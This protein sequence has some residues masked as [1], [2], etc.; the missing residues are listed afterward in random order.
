[1]Y[2]LDIPKQELITKKLIEIG[3]NYD[4]PLVA[5]QNSYYVE[6]EDKTTQDVIM[7]LGTGHEIENPDRPSLTAG[8][9]SFLDEESMQEIFG[10]I[11]EALENTKKI[12]D[13]VDIQ[14]ETGGVLIPKFKL[15]DEHYKIFLEA[16][17]YQKQNPG[18]TPK[19]ELSSDEWYLRYL[20][21]IGLN[22][23]YEEGISK[24]IIFELVQ[25]TDMPS[26]GKALTE[27]SPEELKT[28]SLTYYSKRKKEIL[29][30]LSEDMQNKIE[31]LEYELVVVHE[32]GFDAYFLIVADYIGWARQ[33]DIPV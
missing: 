13:M 10:Y 20:S 9:Y 5:C 7:A 18:T 28:L 12:A 17:E 31:R 22:W 23:R 25:K 21:F 15:P 16:Q 19:K 4:I 26:L 1:M 27:T 29:A 2:H 24:E 3:Q 14:I 11:P 8:D 30:G 33:N 6:K 32:M